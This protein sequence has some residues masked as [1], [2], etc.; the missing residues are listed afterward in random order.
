VCDTHSHVH[1]VQ[2]LF[3]GQAPPCDPKVLLL[4]V[5]FSKSTYTLCTLYVLYSYIHFSGSLP[6]FFIYV[7]FTGTLHKVYIYLGS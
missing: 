5:L 7:E 1:R 3:D 2:Y 4:L 6:N